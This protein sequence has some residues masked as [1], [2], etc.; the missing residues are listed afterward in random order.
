MG[1]TYMQ[2][3]LYK[4]TKD[5]KYMDRALKFQEFIFQTPDLYDVD[6]MREPTPNP[7][8]LYGGSWESAIM[9]WMDLLAV[10]NNDF[11]AATILMPGYEPGVWM[12]G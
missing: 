1:N 2:I 8:G 9:L 4:I 12:L 10:Q 7:Y 3:Y 11:S 6:L 5:L